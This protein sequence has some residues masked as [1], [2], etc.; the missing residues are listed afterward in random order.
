MR[1]QRSTSYMLGQTSLCFRNYGSRSSSIAPSAWLLYCQSTVFF[2]HRKCREKQH[3]GD[4]SSGS[5]NFE[6]GQ[7]DL[8][9]EN[10]AVLRKRL[11]ARPGLSFRNMRT[12]ATPEHFADV[13]SPCK[14]QGL[15]QLPPFSVGLD[16]PSQRSTF[17]GSPLSTQ[18]VLRSGN[19]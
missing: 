8:E 12:T 7:K 13:G 6:L 4:E 15:T 3:K 9:K 17:S 5:Q 1:L 18:V 14:A 16:F 11:F 2:Q 19:G 10:K